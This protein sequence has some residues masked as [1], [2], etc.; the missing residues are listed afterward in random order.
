MGS[1]CR[2]AKI[3]QRE[4]IMLNPQDANARKLSDGDVVRVFNQR[5]ACLAGVIVSDQMMPGVVQMSTG[6]WYDPLDPNRPGSLCK[7]GNP[8]VLNTRHR[9]FYARTG[10]DRTY[11]PGGD[12][13]LF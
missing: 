5:G 8:N 1:Y 12:R 7:H 2:V 4:P 11:L 3:N 10:T 13:T 9:Y 6:A